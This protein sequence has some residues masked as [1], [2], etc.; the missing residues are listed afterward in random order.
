MKRGL[1]AI[2]ICLAAGFAHGS[3]EE[4][5]SAGLKAYPTNA[6]AAYGLFV[7]AVGDGSVEAI[8]AA[9]HCC[10]HGIGAVADEKM[11]YVW[12][13]HAV[14]SDPAAAC[15][16][17]AAIE[18]LYQGVRDGDL[19]ER[20]RRFDEHGSSREDA[21]GHVMQ[22]LTGG[23]QAE[24]EDML[25]RAM[26]KFP[27]DSRFFYERGVMARSRWGKADAAVYFQGVLALEETGPLAEAA[28][29]MI[30]MDQG[31]DIEGG[32]SV[33]R[34]LM[35][36]H[37]DDPFFAW[38][39]AIQCREQKKNSR[40]G[41]EAYEKILA[42]WEPGPVMV[43][44]TYANILTESLGRP[45]SALGHRRIAVELAPRGWTYQGLGNT[46]RELGRYDEAAEA[47]AEAVE[48]D[49]DD[50]YWRQWGMSLYTAGHDEDALEKFREAFAC[51]P[52]DISSLLFQGR[53]LQRLGR[54]E[55]GFSCYK[56]AAESAP[57]HRFAAVYAAL[58]SLY[59]YGTEPDF[60]KAGQFART[61]NEKYPFPAIT[62][63]SCITSSE[64]SN[65]SLEPERVKVLHAHLEA[66]AE[67]GSSAAQY[68][69]GKI[70]ANGLGVE[71]DGVK[72][73]EWYTSSFTHGNTD[74][75]SDL[76]SLYEHG[77]EGLDRNMEKAFFYYLKAAEAGN[78]DA[79]YE[80]G[81]CYLVGLGTGSDVS[82][83]AEWLERCGEHNRGFKRPCRLLGSAYK[84]GSHCAPLNWLEAERWYRKGAESGDPYC[85]MLIGKMYEQGGID[86]PRDIEKA[87][88]L[89][90]EALEKTDGAG[91]CYWALIDLYCR[92]EEIE[93]R[94]PTAAIET[95]HAM[96]ARLPSNS[97]G[98]EAL[99][100]AYAYDGKFKKAVYYQREAIAK[101]KSSRFPRRMREMEQKLEHYLAGRLP[102][103]AE[104]SRA[105]K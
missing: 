88:A 63:R 86:F 16:G 26:V 104:T 61:L 75:A 103:A 23:K 21:H 92:C 89:Y 101:E 1:L 4:L 64:S 77:S 70:Y 94:N 82:K 105:P 96:C 6:A 25:E 93:Y 33:L 58:S 40:E 84:E 79:M 71:K 54:L 50:D 68:N 20:R 35:N 31:A 65:A 57:K 60:D 13:R 29:T 53:T 49:P 32:F 43:H 39:F 72:A 46:L 83:A 90:K 62:L 17:L 56:Q 12:R 78:S 44:H 85:L 9:G 55:E 11:A 30:R 14:H 5:Y 8:M 24:A 81:R 15:R 59:G 18:S 51:N 42:V 67:G 41:A 7:Q 99:A 3:A 19:E 37:S 2:S 48:L 87:I 27:P 91:N 47:F 10:E 73:A 69:L 28:Q 52:S 38:L 34:R 74:A 100:Q 98:P 66:L 97:G 22:L 80:V 95:A 45:E 36:E 76:A 102:E